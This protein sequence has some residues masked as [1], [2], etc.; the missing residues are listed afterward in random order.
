M[1]H[2]HVEVSQTGFQGHPHDDYE[3]V[4]IHRLNE[5]LPTDK[6]HYLEAVISEIS[7]GEPVP[8]Y[9]HGPAVLYLIEGE[10]HIKDKSKP[11]EVTKLVAGDVIHIDEGSHCIFTSPNKAKMFG[12]GYSPSHLH[13]EDYIVKK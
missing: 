5:K 6:S 12:T 11:D 4:K 13:A 2:T 3:H 8:A 10:L 9:Y 7:A 1:P